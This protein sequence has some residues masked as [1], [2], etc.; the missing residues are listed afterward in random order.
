MN[1][2]NQLS[3]PWALSQEKVLQLL[4][5]DS[6]KGLSEKRVAEN[7]A[8]FGSNVLIQ[9]T[10]KTIAALIIEGIKEPMMLLLL[11]IAAL[12][13]VFGKYIEASAMV[14]VVAAYIAVEL[15]NKYRTDRTMVKLRSLASPKSKVIRDGKIFEIESTDIVVGDILVLSEGVFVPADA[16]LVQAYGLMVNEASLT[17]ESM[18]ITK[19][20]D[21]VIA[22]NVP[23]ADR[24][25]SVFA[26]TTVVSGQGTAVI[27]AV[28]SQSNLGTIA[29]EVQAAQKEKTIL[30]ESMTKLAKVLA[31]FALVASAFIPLIGFLRGLG[32]QE[33][34]LTWLSL[35]FLMIP[36]QPPIIITMALA[37]AAFQ[38]A[39]KQVIVKRLR[40]V[41]V[42][43]Q[44]TS[45]V[46]DKT[47]TI[48]E[49]KMVVEKFFFEDKE[50]QQVPD[51]IQKI[52][53][54]ALPDY[55]SDPTDVAVLESCVQKEKNMVQIDFIGFGDNRPWR[56][57]IYKSDAGYFHAFA[58]SPEQIIDASSLTVD[59][60]KNYLAYAMEQAQ[61]GKR[62]TSYAYY[63]SKDKEIKNLPM[64]HFVA[65][66]ILKD[67]VRNGV[68]EAIATLERAGI[69]TYVVTG[70]HKD[71]ARAIAAEI[72]IAGD[73][74]TGDQ[75]EKMTDEQLA[76]MIGQSNILA[77][78]DPSQKVRL[79]GILQ[80]KG[81]IVGTIGDGVNDA[82]A[83][84]TA[85]VGIAMGQ[86]GTDLAKEV[87][88]LILAD[89]NYVH[90]PDAV[91]IGRTAI[92]NFKK[93][94]SYY[95][96][97]KLILLMLFIVPLF[98]GIPFPF[99]P[100]QIICIELLMDL[101]SSTIFVTEA[102]EP[103]VMCHPMESIKAFLGRP[104]VIRIIKN[105][106]GLICA[107]LGIYL[108]TYTAYGQVTA[109]TAAF[110]AW[111]LGHI[112]LALNLKQDKMPLMVQ[113]FFS[114]RFGIW[115]LM[116]MIVFSLAITML[117]R[118]YP[119][120]GTTWLPLNVWAIIIATIFAAT[121]W[122]ELFKIIRY[123]KISS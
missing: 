54:L 113:G 17:G 102:S 12:S 59:Q 94:I 29:Q 37:L 58:G 71:T 56:D 24:I 105:A 67:P 86:I 92:N 101:A 73:I 43:G 26:G 116:G 21:A 38:L 99:V 44:V 78:M 25:N 10:P 61:Q 18:P 53:A 98:L 23:L 33:M 84:K 93:G 8:Q 39:K 69:N 111:L 100:I 108:F 95:L 49:S 46:S 77:R 107:I 60:K 42:I 57:I 81:E 91:A 14:F 110:V 66:A 83:L 75:F 64:I 123:K 72:G 76:T 22:Q 36:G 32:L 35:T 47:G 85:Q 3:M 70:D 90:I 5:V 34:I 45:I 74:I 31:L 103:D 20:A 80:K 68:K 41:E 117:P 63:E 65:L 28:G 109:Q 9:I 104:L 40:G 121:F 89:D 119:Y 4:Q 15:I 62:V 112:L 6:Q 79:V 51:R 96:S 27:T 50:T 97:A 16:R 82:P 118:L 52:I 11:S 55:A 48:T 122:I 13:L 30:Q 7:R 2:E 19:N 88:D 1:R 87:S 106:L 120:F 114:N 115:W